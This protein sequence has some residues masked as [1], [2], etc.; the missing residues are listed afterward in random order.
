MPGAGRQMFDG[1][2][3]E[4]TPDFGCGKASTQSETATLGCILKAERVR[5]GLARRDLE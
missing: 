5:I 3:A 1:N 2:N 4:L